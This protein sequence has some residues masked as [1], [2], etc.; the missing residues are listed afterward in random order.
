M[1]HWVIIRYD[2]FGDKI[3]NE[4]GTSWM[5]KLTSQ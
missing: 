3:F 2:Y 5:S 1:I 4:S